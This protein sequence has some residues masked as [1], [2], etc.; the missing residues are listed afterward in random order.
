MVVLQDESCG[1]E[2][3]RRARNGAEVAHVGHPIQHDEEEAFAG[4]EALLDQF[5]DGRERDG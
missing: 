1:A 5:F 4:F 2:A 3:F